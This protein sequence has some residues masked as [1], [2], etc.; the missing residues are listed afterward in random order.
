MP[1]TQLHPQGRRAATGRL[2]REAARFGVVGVVGF[3][4]DAL[5]LTAMLAAGTGP[6]LGRAASYVAAASVTFWLNRAWTFAS[7]GAA[8]RQWAWFLAVNLVGF[9]LNYGTYAL[10]VARVAVVAG[11][12]VL[13]VA[14]G[15]L[16]GMAGNFFLS[17]RLVF[18]TRERPR[19][20]A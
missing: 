18:N 1:A 12:P 17:R 13:G 5:V 4:V 2:A 10:L 16:A 15:S 6:Y 14:A 11:H 8:T 9:A 7:T 20:A 3:G 19:H